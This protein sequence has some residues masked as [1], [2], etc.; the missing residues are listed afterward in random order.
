MPV[1]PDPDA[2]TYTPPAEPSAPDASFPMYSVIVICQYMYKT[3]CAVRT[4]RQ[5]VCL[6]VCR[7][8]SVPDEQAYKYMMMYFVA[9]VLHTC[10]YIYTCITMIADV[11]GFGIRIPYVRRTID[12][13]AT[14]L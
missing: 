7:D 11:L 5:S 9:T 3:K 1:C 10:T 14:I 4:V 8:S 6:S 2:V 13:E 12:D